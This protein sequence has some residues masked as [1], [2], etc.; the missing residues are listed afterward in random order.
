M[1]NTRNSESIAW[2]ISIDGAEM[3]L[4]ISQ[5]QFIALSGYTVNELAEIGIGDA[6]LYFNKF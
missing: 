4:A 3:V 5:A 2:G 1:T 6:T